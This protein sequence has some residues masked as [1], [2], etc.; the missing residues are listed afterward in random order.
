M[1]NGEYSVSKQSINGKFIYTL[2]KLPS[3]RMGNFETF[4][5]ARTFA[6]SNAGLPTPRIKP[7]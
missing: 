6:E 3:E 4:D 5:D 1:T 7:K 2:W